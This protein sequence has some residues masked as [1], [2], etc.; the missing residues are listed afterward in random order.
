MKI[1]RRRSLKIASG[2]ALA[3]VASVAPRAEPDRPGSP[4]A[5]AGAGRAR[6]GEVPQ[7]ADYVIVGAGSAGCVLARRLSEAGAS[8]I[9]LEAGGFDALPEIREPRAWPGL[10]GSAVDW[11]YKTEAQPQTL[12][13]VHAWARGKVLGGS[14]SINAMAHH[15]G[16][17]S[18]YAAWQRDFGVRGWSFRELL[19]YFRRLETFALGA[20]AYHGA[21]GPIYVDVP[22]GELLHP[23]ARQ[24]VAAG[25]AAGWQ[26]TD[27][28]NGPSMEGPTVN[29]V[30]LKGRERQGPANCY[31]RPALGSAN[32]PT[33]LTGVRATRL[34][35]A[36][37]RCVGVDF[38][39]DAGAPGAAAAAVVANATG[40]SGE[41]TLRAAREVLLCTGSIESPKLLML[42]GLGPPAELAQHGIAVRAALPGVGANLQDHLL[43]AGTVYESARPLPLSNYQHGEGMHYLR[44]DA[45]LPGPDVL[46]MC[47]TVPFASFTL[48]PPPSNAWTILP[49]IMQPRSRGTIRLRSANPADAPLIDPRYFSDP[50]DVATMTRGFEIAREVGGQPALAEWRAREVY[51]GERWRDAA[52]RD[53]FVRDAANTFFH[54]VGTCAMGTG[55]EA[56]VDEA[57]RVRGTEG[58]RVVDASVIPRIPSAAT[59][60]PVIAIAERAADLILGRPVARA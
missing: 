53:A 47:V 24:F 50:V 52:A 38:V 35:F 39:A 56:V 6:G 49:C 25:V 20:S 16:H 28:I 32:P 3:T 14:G 45:T 60:A 22:R 43:G 17:P 11:Q 34:R 30:A 55:P 31:L 51:P 40:G 12:G 29:H 15:R 10:Q 1:T 48:P 26:P 33:L 36:G 54:P 8:V 57:L 42:S 4:G 23:V 13:R 44:T 59:H 21:D 58:L 9:V 41:R 19:P 18:V 46:L 5:R 27:D 37:T 2:L 7:G